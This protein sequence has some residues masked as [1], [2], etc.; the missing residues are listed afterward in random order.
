MNQ[1]Q[2]NAAKKAM[3]DW[4]S[5]PAELG[6]APAK[7]ECAGEFDLHDMHYYIFKYKKGI[8]GKWMLGVA[9]GYEGEELDNCG[10]TF[11]QM[12]EYR[13][14]TAQKDAIDLAEYVIKYIK[15]QA[16]RAEERKKNPGNFLNFVLLKEPVWSKAA[17]LKQLKEDW[18]IEPEETS[19]E[20]ENE[21]NEE[22]VLFPYKGAMIT[23][24]FLPTPVPGGEAE[25]HAGSNYRWKEAV[26]ATRQHKAQV[27]VAIMGS[28]IDVKESARLL[29]KVVVSCCRMGNV[30]GIYANETV[31]QPEFYMDC[32]RMM[33]DDM[34]PIMNL[35]WIGLHGSPKGLSAYTCGM[36]DLG[37]DEMEVI[38]TSAAPGEVLGALLDTCIYVVDNNVILQDGETMGFTPEQ[39]FSITR[40]KGVAVEG[41]SLKI[42]F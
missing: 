39:K 41:E 13:E 32:A 8:F 21:E 6:K 5:H 40:S 31:Y 27:M 35:V 12:L 24:S 18:G 23:A 29:V 4:L 34:F 11:S 26:E 15:E 7:I 1:A 14:A 28:R 38:D 20:G 25:Y 10:H 17:F 42:G 9:G 2:K 37:Y 36:C 22:I 33:R 19:E 30:L 16:E 3:I